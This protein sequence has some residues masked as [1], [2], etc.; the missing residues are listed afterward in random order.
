MKTLHLSSIDF[1]SGIGRP[2]INFA[3]SGSGLQC[4]TFLRG[5]SFISSSTAHIVISVRLPHWAR[6]SRSGPFLMHELFAISG[7]GSLY[8]SRSSNCSNVFTNQT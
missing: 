4:L 7:Q 6:F 8:Q 5:V 1:V 3:I 2:S